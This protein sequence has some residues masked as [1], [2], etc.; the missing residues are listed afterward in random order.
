MGTQ[1]ELQAKRSW[2]LQADFAAIAA[3]VIVVAVGAGTFV[4]FQSEAD[5]KQA[6]VADA[7]FAANRAA[8]QIALGFETFR[9]VSAP[10]AA[11]PSV[12]QIFANPTAC[13][14]SYAPL[15][16]FDT[17]H[18]DI[19]RVDGSVVCS[20][21][22]ADHATT[23]SGAPWLQ[24]SAPVVAAP[25]VDAANGNQ[26]V[27][28]AYPIP[29]LGFLAWFL[30]LKPLGPKL[31]SEYGS[32]V[33]QLEFLVTSSDGSAIV[34]RSVGP[35][36]WTGASL[37]GTPFAQTAGTADRNDVTGR[38][39]WHGQAAVTVSG[40]KGYGAAHQCASLRS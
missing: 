33:H 17:G 40:W 23:Y 37:V 4:H 31:G 26:V 5:A 21:L 16:A 1:G 6:A 28:Y 34:A 14:L 25:L 38:P 35:E 32:G 10:T 8:K 20:S 12:G 7:N 29:G 36:M 11:S 27:V 3:L 24:S 18:I 13:N 15:A 30:D 9:A 39:R 19:V 2:P 22:K